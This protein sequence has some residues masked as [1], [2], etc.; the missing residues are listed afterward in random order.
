MR[1]FFLSFVLLGL[2]IVPANAEEKSPATVSR[3]FVCLSEQALQPEDTKAVASDLRTATASASS[4]VEAKYKA[5]LEA[6]GVCKKEGQLYRWSG[7]W[8]SRDS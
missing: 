4:A 8:Q 1:I 3:S 6:T 5:H 7:D 2:S